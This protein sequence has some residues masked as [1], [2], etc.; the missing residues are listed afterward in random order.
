M[1]EADRAAKFLAKLVKLTQERKVRWDSTPAPEQG[2]DT[3]FVA[4]IEGRRMRLYQYSKEI[5]NPDYANYAASTLTPAITTFTI[6][7]STPRVEPPRTVVRSGTVLE[8]FDDSGRSA[9]KF[10]NRPGLR[11]LYESAAYSA[12]KV[13][14]LIDSVL[15]KD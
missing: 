4:E 9:Y 7:S 14:D 2:S 8:L 10:E 6:L 1:A 12:A 13:D 5:P 3:A 11:D 15:G